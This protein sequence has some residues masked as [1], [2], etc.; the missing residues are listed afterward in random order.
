MT[1]LKSLN[2]LLR[3]QGQG[4]RA[5][6]AASLLLATAL[7]AASCTTGGSGGPGASGSDS[8][9]DIAIGIDMD[10]LDPPQ[11]TT[12]T[13]ANVV[14]YSVETLTKLAKSGKTVPGLATSWHVSQDGQTMTLH[15]RK[16]VT[17]SDGTKFDAKAVKFNLDRLL[18]PK[19]NS[20][21]RAPYTSISRVDAP[22]DA[23]IVLHLSH[24][25]PA[26]PSALSASSSGLVS[27]TSINKDGNSYKN[28]VHPVGTGPYKFDSYQQGDQVVF[29]KNPSYWGRK[30]YY[31]KV[32]FHIVP[33]DATRESLVR[34]GQVDMAVL[35]PVADIHQLQSSS[36]TNVLMAPSDRTIFMAMKTP[37]GP[38]QDPM[39]REAVN[40]AVNKKAIIKH[41]LFGAAQEMTSPVAPSVDGYCR[42]G[43][44]PYDP[45]KAKQL[46]AKAGVKH[47]TLTV[48]TPTGRYLQDKQATDAIAGNLRS[49]GI[50]TNVRTMDWSSYLAATDVP[51]SKQ[52]FDAHL[53]GWAPA[54]L[55][56][57]QQLLQFRSDQ[58]PPAGLETS[59]YKN[60]KVDSLS[61]KASTELN[62]QQRRADYCEAYKQIW[63]DAPW[64]FLWVQKNPIVYSSDVS[65]VSYL[66]NEKFS[67]VYARPKG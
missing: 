45:K 41:V 53:L 52:K 42:T 6:A 13:V 58:A 51:A 55:D 2:R 50:K 33:E 40:Y 4:W 47:L 43:S 28:V 35:P 14:D 16:G 21:Q 65:G 32:V 64:L 29:S 17:F 23:T 27:P 22:N 15:L 63:K 7:T 9:F 24:P 8:T 61:A 38:L 3:R 60:S 54:F 48:G 5:C 49:V 46:L 31:K 12:T 20:P 18:D 10:T 36:D 11:M 26:L 56:S 1:P 67:A 39:V 59:L 57:S 37:T 19:V 62:P 44:Y 34:A 25:D 66:P 30:P